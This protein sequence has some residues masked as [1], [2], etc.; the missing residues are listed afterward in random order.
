MTWTNVFVT[1]HKLLSNFIAIINKHLQTEK[2]L[3]DLNI[4]P[5]CS[6]AIFN[7]VTEYQP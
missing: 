4:K 1:E 5:T 3:T 7:L 6:V 2:V